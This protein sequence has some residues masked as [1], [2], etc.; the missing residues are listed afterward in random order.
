M[1]ECT[2]TFLR[3]CRI[4]DQRKPL[5][6]VALDGVG[7]IV[8]GIGA[9]GEAKVDDRRG[10]RIVACIAPKQ[11][12]SMQIVVRPQRLQRGKQRLQLRMK[13]RKQFQ[14]LV[15]GVRAPKIAFAANA[16]RAAR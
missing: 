5:H 3:V 15:R 1:I 13:R 7:K 9:V 16:G 8:H 14:R 10:L 11:I 12:R 6:D 4:F 2:G